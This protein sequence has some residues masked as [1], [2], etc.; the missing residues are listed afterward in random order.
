MFEVDCRRCRSTHAS[1][2]A[3]RSCSL[4]SEDRADDGLDRVGLEPQR[5]VE[6]PARLGR[7]SFAELEVAALQARLDFREPPG[8]LGLDDGVAG[9]VDVASERREH[10]HSDGEQRQDECF[11]GLALRPAQDPRAGPDRAR[12]DRAPLEDRLEIVGERGGGLVAAVSHLLDGG[13]H[14]DGEIA[15][16]GRVQPARIRR[17]RP[18]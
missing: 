18:G 13:E 2:S 14:A 7:V 5:L 12:R 4:K 15:R 3:S 6:D 10:G 1:A 17:D 9:G 8:P 16:D 11:R